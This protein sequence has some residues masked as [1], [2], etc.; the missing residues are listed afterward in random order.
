MEYDLFLSILRISHSKNELI[1]NG[2]DKIPL[3]ANLDYEACQKYGIKLGDLKQIEYE[4]GDIIKQK[5]AEQN[6]EIESES[7]SP[8]PTVDVR[9]IG[10]DNGLGDYID[11]LLEN[12]YDTLERIKDISKSDLEDMGI[13]DKNI[14]DILNKI[15]HLTPK[16]VSKSSINT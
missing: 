4:L 12:G 2:Y 16:R 9:K 13:D 11:T 3:L 10:I 1:E 7:P 8:S 14:D 15:E 6:I 5:K